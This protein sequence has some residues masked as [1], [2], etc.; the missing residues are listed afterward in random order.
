MTKK[1]NPHAADNGY[2]DIWE[3]HVR[4][5]CHGLWLRDARLATFSKCLTTSHDLDT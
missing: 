1:N 4:P 2:K 3:D 5:R